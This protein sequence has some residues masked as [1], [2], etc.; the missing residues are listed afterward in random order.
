M[1][2]NNPYSVNKELN[3]ELYIQFSQPDKS[4]DSKSVERGHDVENHKLIWR[5][6]ETAQPLLY[7][8][9]NNRAGGLYGRILTEVVSTDRTQWGLYSRQVKFLPYRP[10]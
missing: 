10:T 1:Y 7:L 6:T 3:W 8:A 4:E 9:L 2:V 5:G